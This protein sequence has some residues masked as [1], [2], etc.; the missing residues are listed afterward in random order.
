M[1]KTPKDI[2]EQNAKIRLKQRRMRHLKKLVKVRVIVPVIAVAILVLSGAFAFLNSLKYQS[3]DD[4]F[5][6]GSL[7]SIAPKVSGQVIS[8]KVNDNDFV[9][10]G[11]LLLEIDPKDYEN[12]VKQLE[13]ALKR[14]KQIKAYLRAIPKN[15]RQ[16]FLTV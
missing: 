4:A 11:Q 12:K 7:I 13:S 15:Q 10:K 2:F 5:I 16:T 8:L 9:K 6:E 3:T 1:S 14:Q